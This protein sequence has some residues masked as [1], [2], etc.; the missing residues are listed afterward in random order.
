M[1]VLGLHEAFFFFFRCMLIVNIITMSTYVELISVYKKNSKN[2]VKN[3]IKQTL[4]KHQTNK[5]ISK[6][7]LHK[8][9]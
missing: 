5:Q 2:S 7:Q 4:S 6:T 8:M 1:L 3:L 9:E